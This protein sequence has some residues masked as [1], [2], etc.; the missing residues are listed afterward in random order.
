MNPYEKMSSN[1]H[2]SVL[3]LI[4][5]L[6][7]SALLIPVFA[8][9]PDHINNVLILVIFAVPLLFI[10]AL[11]AISEC[12]YCYKDDVDLDRT[13]AMIGPMMKSL[14]LSIPAVLLYSA[15]IIILKA[16]I[17]EFDKAIEPIFS[18][19]IQGVDP[20]VAIPIINFLPI[21]VMIT[22]LPFILFL[23]GKIH[24]LIWGEK[25]SKEEMKKSEKERQE[26]TYQERLESVLKNYNTHMRQLNLYAMQIQTIPDE[27]ER[28]NDPT[29]YKNLHMR[30]VMMRDYVSSIEVNTETKSYQRIKEEDKVK[31]KIEQ[32]EKIKSTLT[33]LIKESIATLEEDKKEFKPSDDD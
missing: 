27:I 31:S 30:L 20:I 12:I 32:F 17:E 15:I 6:I 1:L 10:V 2:Q 4:L 29:K 8:I 13:L 3:A 7:F 18:E 16:L 14:F 25:E 23:Y 19:V 21:F 24:V 11:I 22:A 5:G 33:K 26:K 28:V 9:N